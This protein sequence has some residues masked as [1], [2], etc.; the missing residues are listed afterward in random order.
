MPKAGAL[1][2]AT[3]GCAASVLPGEEWVQASNRG[4]LTKAIQSLKPVKKSGPWEVLCDNEGF[5]NAKDAK[6]MYTKIGV[7]LWRVPPRSPD[8]NPVEKFWA[9]LR[10]QLRAMD[11][12]DAIAKRP[13]LTKVAYR[14]R[15]RRLCAS[16]KA[17]RVASNIALGLRK[18]C[19][20][21]KLKRGAAS[22]G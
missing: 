3:Y 17:Q 18:T 10:K 20:E 9:W 7:K 12:R 19:K 13:L 4:A 5:L 14:E 6:A 1:D 2:S 15:I 16:Q 21:V 22:R 11:L 8:L